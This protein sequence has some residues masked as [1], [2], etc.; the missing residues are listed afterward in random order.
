MRP[1]AVD[2]TVKSR[3]AVDEMNGASGMD[4]DLGG[5]SKW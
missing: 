3:G 2:N 5:L 1:G 4:M